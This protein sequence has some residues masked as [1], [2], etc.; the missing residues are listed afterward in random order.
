M[1]KFLVVL[2]SFLMASSTFPLVSQSTMEE[3]YKI[4]D[5]YKVY[6]SSTDKVDISLIYIFHKL[7][8]LKLDIPVILNISI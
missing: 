1:K 4:E 8:K 7:E 2:F 6:H 5:H 3:H